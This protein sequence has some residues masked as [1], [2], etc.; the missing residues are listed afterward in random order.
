MSGKAI[1]DGRPGILEFCCL[2]RFRLLWRLGHGAEERARLLLEVLPARLFIVLLPYV[3]VVRVVEL[4]VDEVCEVV[5]GLVLAASG[6]ALSKRRPRYKY[7]LARL[8]SDDRVRFILVCCSLG[9]RCLI[10]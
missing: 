2:V 10:S 9:R 6:Q 5:V 3:S 4:T 1:L 8:F 7:N